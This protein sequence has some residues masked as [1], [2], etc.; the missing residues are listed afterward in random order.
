M[1]FAWTS[2]IKTLFFFFFPDTEKN[3]HFFGDTRGQRIQKAKHYCK[4]PSHP[5]KSHLFFSIFFIHYFCS[6]SFT[7]SSNILNKKEFNE[8]CWKQN[9]TASPSNGTF[10]NDALEKNIYSGQEIRKMI[11][12]FSCCK[13][14]AANNH[15]T[16]M[17][18]SATYDYF[19]DCHLF[20]SLQH[21]LSGQQFQ[22]FQN[23]EEFTESKP[24][25]FF[26]NSIQN[27][28]ERFRK[29]FDNRIMMRLFYMIKSCQ[30]GD[31]CIF[32]SIQHYNFLLSH[33]S[34]FIDK[35]Y[36]IF[37]SL[38]NLIFLIEDNKRHTQ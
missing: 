6:L 28:A 17:E 26:Y 37:A 19:S 12:L 23:I 27:L 20:H 9:F 7:F 31:F 16:R 30:L 4:D 1:G 21:S 29:Y 36:D 33:F 18:T 32:I 3:G 25:T 13:C 8:N 34:S 24:K 35:K 38:L 14:N 2:V 5:S 10:L 15:G 22:C 11:L